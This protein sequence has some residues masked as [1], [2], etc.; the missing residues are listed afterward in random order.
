[1]SAAEPMDDHLSRA[2]GALFASLILACSG[3]TAAD[4]GWIRQR[5][6]TPPPEIRAL[7]PEWRTAMTV[8]DR[9]SLARRPFHAEIVKAD[10][11]STRLN[12]SHVL[13]SRM[14]SSA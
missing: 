2:Q 11:K 8:P 4:N 7:V 9:T 14:P 5:P 10:R 12:S 1:M 3:A 13:R 6:G